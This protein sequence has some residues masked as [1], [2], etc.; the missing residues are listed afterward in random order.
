MRRPSATSNSRLLRPD[1]RRAHLSQAA[2]SSPR[3]DRPRSQ[4]LRPLRRPHPRYGSSQ[5]RRPHRRLHRRTRTRSDRCAACGDELRARPNF[6]AATCSWMPARPGR[7]NGSLQS[8]YPHHRRGVAAASPGTAICVAEG[9]YREEI[10][11]GEKYLTFAGG[12]Q[13]GFAA[14]D[15][16]A[17]VTRARWQRR[18]LVHPL[19]GSRRRKAMRAL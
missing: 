11:P 9:T 12:F 7:G 3:R 14:R 8:P 16:A 2:G 4:P 15:S 13:R 17:F 5:H 19:R 1:P 18:R 10:K 6:R